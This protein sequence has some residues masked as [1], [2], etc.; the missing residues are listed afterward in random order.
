MSE[1]RTVRELSRL[2]GRVYVFLKDDLTGERFLRA[3]EA[4]GFTFGDGV[5][6][7]ERHYSQVMAVNADGT[8]C[9][10]GGAGMTAFGAKAAQV[11]DCPLV[12]VD[13][14]RYLSGED[15]FILE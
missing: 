10:V 11:G 9:F 2:Q 5:R 1:K 4:E 6:P 12:R 13:F 7:T 8:L 3:A 14:D 15:P